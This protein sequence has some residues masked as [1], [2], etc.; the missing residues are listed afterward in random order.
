MSDDE[1]DTWEIEMVA[2]HVTR[3]TFQGE[4]LT[5]GEAGAVLEDVGRVYCRRDEAHRLD[6][7]QAETDDGVPCTNDATDGEY[8]GVH[9]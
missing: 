3:V 2:D 5:K 8:C 9:A 6:G 4:T 7:C 1:P